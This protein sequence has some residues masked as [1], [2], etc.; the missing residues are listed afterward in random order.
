MRVELVDL[1]DESQLWGEQYSRKADDV[2][3]VE[4]EIATHI[5]ENLRLKLTGEEKERLTRMHTESPEANRLYLKGRYFWGKRNEE[6]IRKGIDYF[7]QAI[8]I[9]P[10]YAV[11][12]VGMADS[13]AVL[14]FHSIAH[15]GEAFPRAKA[16]ALTALE[17]DPTL[18]EARAPL[19]YAM[20]HY[21][22]KWAEAE[23]EYRR[24]L[25]AIPNYADGPQLLRQHAEPARA[26]R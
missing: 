24:C 19:A 9:D 10:E 13:Y 18:A 6:A 11:A 5:S 4:N 22:W 17:L 16:A 2:L 12:Y 21:E 8:E 3:A 14:G 1:A 25:E 23:A 26:I 20:H 15:P 7:R